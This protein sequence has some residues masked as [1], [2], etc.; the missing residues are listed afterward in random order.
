M[1]LIDDIPYLKNEEIDYIIQ[2]LNN[3]NQEEKA[4]NCSIVFTYTTTESNLNDKLS[5]D[6]GNQKYKSNE[7][8]INALKKNNVYNIEFIKINKTQTIKALKYL[9]IFS[10]I[11]ILS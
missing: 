8:F 7:K 1:L 5:N 2:L 10:S 3:V 11:K 6:H 4:G 9:F